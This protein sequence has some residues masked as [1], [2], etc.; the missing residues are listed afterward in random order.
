MRGT[1]QGRAI[2]L[3]LEGRFLCLWGLLGGEVSLEGVQ[4][5]IL[6]LTWD[7]NPQTRLRSV[8]G[9]PASLCPVPVALTG[10][11]ADPTEKPPGSATTGWTKC[12]PCERSWGRGGGPRGG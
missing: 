11:K 10:E 7:L 12:E 1:R 3:R 8:L 9:P 6:P 2:E 4:L 5:S